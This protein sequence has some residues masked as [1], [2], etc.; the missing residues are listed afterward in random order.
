MHVL[1]LRATQAIVEV[2]DAARWHAEADGGSGRGCR[3][4]QRWWMPP[5]A[6][7]SLRLQ[8][9]MKAWSLASSTS[10]AAW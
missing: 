2:H 7:S 6:A 1:L 5:L 4:T 9:Q 8:W 3:A 10:S